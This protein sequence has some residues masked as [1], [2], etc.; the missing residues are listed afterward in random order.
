MG[1]KSQSSRQLSA[2]LSEPGNINPFHKH[3]LANRQ[4]KYGTDAGRQNKSV[5]DTRSDGKNA[6]KLNHNPST[7][8]RAS[9]MSALIRQNT[10]HPK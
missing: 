9:L 1:T 5:T 10:S 2:N 7:K 6:M 3:Y 8:E 4:F